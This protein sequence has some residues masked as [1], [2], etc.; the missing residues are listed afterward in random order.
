MLS[1]TNKIQL[2]TEQSTQY[3]RFCIAGIYHIKNL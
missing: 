3:L 1:I 2:I